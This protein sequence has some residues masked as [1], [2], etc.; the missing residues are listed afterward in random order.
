MSRAGSAIKV[1]DAEA[2]EA[3]LRSGLYSLFARSMAVPDPEFHRAVEEGELADAFA[4][5]LSGLPHLIEVPDL[6]RP[7]S[8]HRDLQADYIGFFEVGL[9]GPPCPLYEGA[10]RKDM[11]RKAVME[12]LLRFY[13][14]FGLKM[15]EKVREL[16]DQLGAE[17]EFMH[18]LAFLEAGECESG[19][20]AR[21][22]LLRAQ[23]DFLA[24]RLGAWAPGL[25]KRAS[26]RDAPPPYKN[27]LSLLNDFIA[28]D[29]ARLDEI[30]A[31]K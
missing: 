10:F 8:S 21:L 25:A 6:G 19:S 16:P 2:R 4:E 9:K 31:N 28:A 17:L 26:E 11:G 1:G 27:L 5:A 18:Y 24:R 29:A 30:L 12:D 7:P 13:E 20:P 15:S 14:H 22:D 3:A 23:R